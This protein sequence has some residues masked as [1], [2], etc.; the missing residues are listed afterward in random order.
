MSFEEKV[1]PVACF[2]Q[3]TA[4]DDISYLLRYLYEEKMYIG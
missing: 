1:F 4:L 3:K 2:D